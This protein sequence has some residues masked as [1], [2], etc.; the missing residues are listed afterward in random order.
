MSTKLSGN[1]ANPALDLNG[2][3][4]KEHTM[5]YTAE[6]FA[7]HPEIRLTRGGLVLVALLAGGDYDSVC[8]PLSTPLTRLPLHRAFLVLASALGAL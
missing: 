5:V 6:A 7:N 8:P 2:N 1:K 4:S 3:P